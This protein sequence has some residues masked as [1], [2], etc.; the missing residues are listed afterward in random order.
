MR[1]AIRIIAALLGIKRVVAYSELIK[2]PMPDGSVEVQRKD[3]T[4]AYRDNEELA[5]DL[6]MKPHQIDWK[7]IHP[8]HL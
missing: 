6:C 3:G 5:G 8:S 1:T 7:Q 4:K 2:V